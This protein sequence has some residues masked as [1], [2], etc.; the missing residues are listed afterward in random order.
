MARVQW[1]PQGLHVYSHQAQD[2]PYDVLIKVRNIH[3]V[4]EE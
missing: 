1:E 3:G 2:L 4:R